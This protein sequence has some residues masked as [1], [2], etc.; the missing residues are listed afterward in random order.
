MCCFKTK[1]LSFK[2]AWVQ[3]RTWF[4]AAFLKFKMMHSRYME[5]GKYEG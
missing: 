3:T 5:Y 4:H 2:I 1:V